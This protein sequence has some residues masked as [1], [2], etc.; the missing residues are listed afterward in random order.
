MAVLKISNLP[1][2]I[3]LE[4]SQGATFGPIRFELV[5]P[6]PPDGD[7]LAVDLT[8][9]TI[10]GKVRKTFLASTATCTFVA[11]I[12]DQTTDKGKFE[13]KL[14][15]T[16]TAAITCGEKVTD[17]ASKYVWD[18]ELVDTDSRVTTLFR[19]PFIVEAEATK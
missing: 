1:E 13:I 4:C 16:T 10:R 11:T 14:S 12:L 18:V 17:K 5:N 15:D 9:C 8:G 2:K 7:G 6:D 19:G 3:T